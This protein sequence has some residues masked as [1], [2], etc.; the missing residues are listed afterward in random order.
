MMRSVGQILSCASGPDESDAEDDVSTDA[1]NNVGVVVVLM[2][3][4]IVSEDA[5][6]CCVDVL[7]NGSARYTLNTTGCRDTIWNLNKTSIKDENDDKDDTVFN[8]GPNWI[9]LHRIYSGVKYMCM[10]PDIKMHTP[11][12][13]T[14]PCK[15]GKSGLRTE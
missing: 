2:E 10:D 6:W 5:P 12:R 4:L 14:D 8:F 7:A 9:L 13:C 15:S 1:A 3:D 11:V